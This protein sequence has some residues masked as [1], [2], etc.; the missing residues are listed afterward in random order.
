MPV[1]QALVHEH[2]KLLYF[3]HPFTRSV[4]S[5]YAAVS[6]DPYL[7][8]G[9]EMPTMK[10]LIGTQGYHQVAIS[11]YG[12]DSKKNYARLGPNTDDLLVAISALMS[13]QIFRIKPDML[14]SK[15]DFLYFA[16]P[17]S[18]KVFEV[19][20]RSSVDGQLWDLFVAAES[21]TVSWHPWFRPSYPHARQAEG[22]VRSTWS[23]HSISA[24]RLRRNYRVGG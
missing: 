3:T 15:N 19:F 16:H 21:T 4:Y 10:D 1:S 18:R 24:E 14:I 11:E 9:K 8:D 12:D 23:V 5:L 13:E 22:L 2:D 6:D 17:K 7:V 20:G